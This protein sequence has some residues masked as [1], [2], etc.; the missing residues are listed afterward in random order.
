MMTYLDK[1]RKLIAVVMNGATH[2]GELA[3]A[4]AAFFKSIDAQ[5]T[6]SGRTKEE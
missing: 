3:N 2:S 6:R 5:T 1:E 4:A